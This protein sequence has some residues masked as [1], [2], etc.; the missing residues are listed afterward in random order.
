MVKVN[1][2]RDFDGQIVLISSSSAAVGVSTHV[3]NLAKMLHSAG[4]IDIVVC[5]DLGWLT[6]R[7][8]DCGIPYTVMQM[9]YRPATFAVSAVSMLKFVQSRP[10][11]SIIH[12]HG[13]CPLFLSGLSMLL[14]PEM[15]FVATVHQFSQAGRPGICGWKTHMETLFLKHVKRICCVSEALRN[16]TI[17]R[18][19]LGRSSRVQTIPNWIEPFWHQKALCDTGPPPR[20]DGG[21]RRICGIG[22]LV[23]DKGFDILITAIA[24]LKTRGYNVICDIYGDGPEAEDLNRQIFAL[25]VSE[26]VVLSGVENNVRRV[27]V[28]Y[29]IL[30]IPS[31]T[32]SFGITALEAF[33]ASVP[34]VAS[35][36]E[37]LRELVI[38][39]YSGMCFK[40]EDPN[41]LANA[42]E[43]LLEDTDIRQSVISNGYKVLDKHLPGDAFLQEYREFYARSLKA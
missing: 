35:D 37:G 29:E 32:E 12:L 31:R 7:L 39:G 43:D 4:K 2:D 8:K 5:P 18:I 6:D 25:G 22:R 41:S 42:L 16:E 38:H 1:K 10:S 21:R 13:R 15:P 3:Y 28:N 9:S 36:I 20:R 24:G 19:G 11:K 40:S 33:D 26:S 30:V 14:N 17:L 23:R 27:L 34:V